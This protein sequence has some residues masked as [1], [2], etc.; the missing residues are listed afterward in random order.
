MALVTDLE[1]LLRCAALA[2]AGMV[3]MPAHAVDCW[4]RCS[5][6]AQ[7][8]VERPPAA[9]EEVP[10]RYTTPSASCAT[11]GTLKQGDR[12]EGMVRTK[13]GEVHLFAATREQSVGALASKFGPADCAYDSKACRERRDQA[14]VAGRAGKAFDEST[15]HK[16]TGTP[17]TIGLP[18]GI[19]LAPTQG[20]QLRLDDAGT[21]AALL[22]I[23]ALRMASGSIDVPVTAGRAKVPAGF[24]RAGASY[25]YA[26][27][28]KSGAVIA[29][30]QF[31]AAG[32]AIE[33]DVRAEEAKALGAGL[34][35]AAARLKSLL[36]NELDWDAMQSSRQ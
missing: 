1:A 18:C 30:G 12:I 11:L 17:C 24:V 20:W 19:V 32:P 31:S 16:P 27:M 26:L 2:L 28:S 23:A 6:Q 21:D 34:S 36:V 25:S 22:Q 29:A 7:C 5:G 13:N 3:S 9:M 14:M 10:D 4:L 15:G 33:A 35:P 8:K